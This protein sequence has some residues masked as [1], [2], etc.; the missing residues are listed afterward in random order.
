MISRQEKPSRICHSSK[1]WWQCTR[2]RIWTH[3]PHSP[4][5][6]HTYETGKNVDKNIL[7]KVEIVKKVAA[8]FVVSYLGKLLGKQETD[9][10]KHRPCSVAGSGKTN[11]LGQV[12]YIA[13]AKLLKASERLSS[14]CQRKPYSTR[15]PDLAETHAVVLNPYWIFSTVY[16]SFSKNSNKNLISTWKTFWVLAPA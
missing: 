10:Q 11:G 9:E 16:T 4:V 13:Q 6:S 15:T 5:G 12:I 1:S 3:G 2:S 7:L 8:S 14:Q